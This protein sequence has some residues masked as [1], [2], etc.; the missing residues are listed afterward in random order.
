[1]EEDFESRENCHDVLKSDDVCG[2]AFHFLNFYFYEL[3][4][5]AVLE[6]EISWP[7]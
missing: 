2:Y 3:H 5:A 4:P 1:M 6:L 7:P